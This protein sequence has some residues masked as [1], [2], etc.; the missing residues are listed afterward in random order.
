MVPEGRARAEG[1]R[2][3]PPLERLGVRRGGGRRGPRAGR[4]DRDLEL[5][6]VPGHRPGRRGVAVLAAHP[7]DAEARPDHAD[8]DAQRGRAASSA[9]SPSPGPT[10]ADEFHLFG[11]L[12]AEVH[13]SRWFRHHLPDDGSVRFEV[14]GLGLTGLSVTGPRSRDVL[15]AVAPDLD[16]STE[17]FPFM[18]FRRV[19]LGMV[20]AHVA[21]I[22][23]SG[24]L[25]YELWVASGAPAR[26]VRP[27]RGGR[28]SPRPAAV[29]D[30]RAD[31]ACASRRATGRGSAST[32]R[33]TRALEGGITRYIKL[34]HEFIG[35]AAHEREMAD[36]GPKR[37][38][39]DVRR[40]ARARTIRPTSSATS[41]S[42]TTAT[43]VGWITSGGYG[44]HVKQSIA[45][46]YVPTELSTPDGPGGDGFEIEIIGRR[47]PARLQPEP[48][49]D[50]AGAED[51][52]VTDRPGS[53]RFAEAGRIVVDG[54]PVAVR[55][56]RLGRDRDPAR[57]GR[58]RPGRDAVPDRRLR[59][60]PGPG[61][62][63]R[64]RPDVPAAGTA[65]SRRSSA[66]RRTGCRR[67]PAVSGPDLTPSPFG[68][69]IEVLRAACRCRGDRWWRERQGGRRRRREGRASGCSSSMPRM[70]TRSSASIR[71]R[72]LVVRTPTLMLHVYAARDRRRDRRRRD[73]P[74][75]PGND[76][77][78]VVTSRAARRMHAAGI[79]LGA[80]VAIGT[81]PPGVPCI[82]VAGQLMRIEG[83]ER[84]RVRAVVTADDWI[85]AETTTPCDT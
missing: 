42:G 76:L 82:P 68:P 58:P 38:L 34:D 56:R 44:H 16:L 81:P 73:P 50:P 85:G 62:W 51:A 30:A 8:G 63:R 11:S 71:G 39:V 52:P 31:V 14:L 78:G 47:R 28:R 40:R 33:S 60:L 53:A 6:E 21:R 37:R 5:R 54:R 26:P 64:L 18:T 9:S 77:E 43:V 59:Q 24:D 25:G 74:G 3:V 49:F 65:G 12:P 61:R 35:R 48:L 15:G 10:E 29:R 72:L 27:D 2:D 22:N 19:D 67:C 1:G 4:D 23:Y 55:R 20:P 79:E 41:R 45:L 83:D 7:A 84:G 75:R 36:G 32:A 69:D 80:A 46:G 70:A 57:R 13:H 17:A 66:T